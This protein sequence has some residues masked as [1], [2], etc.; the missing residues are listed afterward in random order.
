MNSGGLSMD[1]RENWVALRH[2]ECRGLVSPKAL[3]AVVNFVFTFH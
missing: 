1:L 2:K 3:T